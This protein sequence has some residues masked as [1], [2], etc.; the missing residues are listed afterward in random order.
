MTIEFFLCEE[1]LVI[2]EL[3]CRVHNS[4]H[5]SLKGANISQFELHLRA[6]LDLDLIKPEILSEIAM[7]NVI[8]MHPQTES[9]GKI[10]GVYYVDYGKQEAP[11][12]KL[13]HVNILGKDINELNDKIVSVKNSLNI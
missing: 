4:G 6:I 10:E 12:R 3:A 5:W 11:N 7:V 1:E 8:G 13:G 9:L 2:N